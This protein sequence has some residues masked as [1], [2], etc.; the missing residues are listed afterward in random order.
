MAQSIF[1]CGLKQAVVFSLVLPVSW[2]V[3]LRRALCSCLQGSGLELPGGTG[4]PGTR[5]WEAF[6]QLISTSPGQNRELA[7]AAPLH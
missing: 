4:L 5:A 7:A 2:Q 3:P 6:A 1:C